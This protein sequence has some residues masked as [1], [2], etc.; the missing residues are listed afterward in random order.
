[1][2]KKQAVDLWLRKYFCWLTELLVEEEKVIDNDLLRMEVR[3]SINRA[4]KTVLRAFIKIIINSVELLAL[5]LG[6]LFLR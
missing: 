5:I 6:T 4:D 2:L 1:M 3:C